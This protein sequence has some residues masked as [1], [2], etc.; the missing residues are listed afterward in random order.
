MLNT[1]NFHP[2]VV[3]FPIALILVGFLAEVLSLF[4]KSE[5][6]LSRTGF[7]LLILGAVSAIVAWST[8]QLF[9]TEPTQGAVTAVFEKHET[10]A[11]I[12]MLLVIICSLFRIYLVIKKKEDSG[13]KWIAFGVYF[14]AF[15]AVSITGFLGGTMVYDF[16]MAL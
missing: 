3:H 10:A 4:F 5:K 6:C 9:T 11:L 16:M 15:A 13:L 2:I 12:T 8:G 7:Y 1:A 14:L